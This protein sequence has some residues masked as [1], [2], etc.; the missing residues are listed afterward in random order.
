M[1]LESVDTT[2]TASQIGDDDKSKAPSEPIIN[3]PPPAQVCVLSDVLRQA[4]SNDEV[5]R[6]SKGQASS[7]DEVCPTEVKIVEQASSL[8]E[9]SSKLLHR[10]T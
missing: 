6:V 5:C 9:V 2:T 8:D 3:V 1:S 7:S 10:R 4:S